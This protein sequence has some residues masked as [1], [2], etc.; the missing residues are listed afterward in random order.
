[1]TSTTLS[2]KSNFAPAFKKTFKQGLLNFISE[3][4]L[5]VLVSVIAI[6]ITFS[7]YVDQYYVR[8]EVDITFGAMSVLGIMTV[9]CGFSS[10]SLAPKMFKEIYKKQ[11]CDMYF[12]LPIKRRDYYTS[13]YLLGVI[14]NVTGLVL[15]CALYAGIM[16]AFSN[17]N[18]Q[19]TMDLGA[20]M[21]VFIAVL[22]ALLAIYSAFVMCAVT[23]GKKIQYFLLA[24]I[25]LFCTSSALTGV[26]SN[27]NQIWGLSVDGFA[28]MAFDPMNN[29]INAVFAEG[30]DKMA[31]LYIVSA[32][33]I[34]GMFFAGLIIFEKRKAEVAE[35]TLT[36]KIIPYILLVDLAV[37]AYMYFSGTGAVSSIILGIICAVLIAMAFSGIFYKKV[38]TK[39]TGITVGAVCLACTVFIS[40]VYFPGHSSYVKK[41]PDA[42][43]VE[44]IEISNVSV[45]SINLSVLTNLLSEYDLDTDVYSTITVTGE[46]A[47]A[48]TIA[49]HQKL[50]DDNVIEK[51]QSYT[52]YNLLTMLMNSSVYDDYYGTYDVRLTYHLKSGKTLSRTSV[53][54]THLTLPT[55]LRV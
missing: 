31:A 4:V 21:P 22:M 47:I 35:V 24:L 26:L 49:L 7:N 32:I 39:K 38:F 23:A 37:A 30:M 44:S 5:A 34:V 16:P 33:E 2:F 41:V 14:V 1:M 48:D 54:Y 29:A 9:I 50:V 45:N 43:Q 51:S 13:A 11:S 3:L 53:S 28:V 8:G 20:F 36:G 46:K 52:N 19:F 6:M 15:S 27:L 17:K 55:I 40:C 10:L 42:S 12:S 18:V 25:C